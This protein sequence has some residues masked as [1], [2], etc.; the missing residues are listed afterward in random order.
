[1][2]RGG[3]SLPCAP[4]PRGRPSSS[5]ETPSALPGRI[6]RRAP[7]CMCTTCAPASPRPP[8]TN[9]ATRPTPC[10]SLPRARFWATAGRTDAPPCATN[11]GSCRRWAASTAS[12]PPWCVKTS[13]SSPAASTGSTPLP[14]PTAA[15]RWGTTMPRRASSSPRWC[16]TRTRAVCWCSPSAAR[17]SRR[18]SS[19]VNSASGT[20]GA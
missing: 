3:T 1:M 16:A 8:N 17:T 12:P 10:P 7:G 9:I 11:S 14:T 5:T 15:A 20:I 2:W 6:F 13:T 18:S 19:S 4:S